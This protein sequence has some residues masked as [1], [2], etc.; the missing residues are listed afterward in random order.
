[1]IGL[2]APTGALAAFNQIQSIVGATEHWAIGGNGWENTLTFKTNGQERM[3]ITSGGDVG[4]GT[5][6]P[7]AKLDVAGNVKWSGTAFLPNAGTI[8]WGTSDSAGIQGRDNS[9]GNGYLIFSV[10]NEKMRILPSGNVGIGTTAPTSGIELFNASGQT[11]A[12]ITTGTNVGS[13]I[14]LRHNSAAAGAGGGVILGA[15]GGNFAAIKGLLS[16]GANNTTGDLAFATRGAST[17]SAL[18]ER[19]RIKDTGQTRFVP[20]AADPAGA[21]SGDVYYNSG[22]NKL[23]VYNGTAWVDLH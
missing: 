9:T 16:N 2:Y 13:F 3:R 1:L 15:Q 7:G 8:Q 10:N 17:D 12:A 11:T 18:T 5:S 4:I 23:R 22:T 20:L 6:S 14:T 19:M 21:E